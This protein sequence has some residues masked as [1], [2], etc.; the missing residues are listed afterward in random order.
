VDRDV[1]G[2]E[3]ASDHAPTWVTLEEIESPLESGP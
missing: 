1:R 2:W 3:R